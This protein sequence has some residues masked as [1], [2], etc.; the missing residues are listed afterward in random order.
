MFDTDPTSERER[1]G[2]QGGR[3]GPRRST[4]RHRIILESAAALAGELGYGATTIEAIAARAGA[5]KQTIYRWWPSKAALYL[6]VYTYLVPASVLREDTGSV[7]EDLTALLKRLFKAYRETPA[8]TILAGLITEAQGDNGAARVLRDG[9]VVGRR[10]LLV[11]P[12]ERGIARGDVT[13]DFDPAEANE[14]I[15]A[16]IWHRLLTRPESLDDDFAAH[17]VATVLPT[18]AAR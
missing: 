15:V 4:A 12:I 8:A 5:G 18:R 14:T 9:L 3:T 17:L 11:E 7:A 13:A 6:E 1:V 2:L 16:R 10:R